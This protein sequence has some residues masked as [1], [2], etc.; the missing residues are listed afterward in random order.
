MK[1]KKKSGVEIH[2]KKMCGI[3]RP[4][5]YLSNMFR[6][7]KVDLRI[8]GRF[9]LKDFS[10]SIEEGQKWAVTGRSGAGKTS[11]LR[12]ILGFQEPASGQIYYMN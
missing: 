1:N 10:L 9:I 7:E 3:I 6:F 2:L 11:L 5:S 4:I 8:E 12:L